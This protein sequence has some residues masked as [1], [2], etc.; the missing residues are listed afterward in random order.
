MVRNI[1]TNISLAI[2][3]ITNPMAMDTRLTS[4][5][6]QPRVDITSRKVTPIARSTPNCNV[7]DLIEIIQ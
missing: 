2:P 3:P 5:C 6:P 1:G 4:S 7:R